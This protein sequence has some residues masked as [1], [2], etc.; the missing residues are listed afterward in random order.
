[1]NK[2]CQELRTKMNKKLF[3]LF[4][5]IFSKI[6]QIFLTYNCRVIVRSFLVEEVLVALITQCP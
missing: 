4:Q 2:N 6:V 3:F 5:Q 1:M